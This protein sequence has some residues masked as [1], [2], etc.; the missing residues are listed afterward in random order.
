MDTSEID[1]GTIESLLNGI[2]STDSPG[3]TLSGVCKISQLYIDGLLSIKEQP[4]YSELQRGVL[5]SLMRCGMLSAKAV[6]EGRSNLLPEIKNELSKNS[7]EFKRICADRVSRSKYLEKSRPLI[8]NF[9]KDIEKL[10]LE[11][12][13]DTVIAI[14]AGGL[15]PAFAIASLRDTMKLMPIRLSPYMMLDT[16]IRVPYAC[17]GSYLDEKM[18][19]KR[20]LVVDDSVF[21]GFTIYN[22]MRFA[23]ESGAKKTCG[24]AVE[25]INAEAVRPVTKMAHRVCG[26]TIVLRYF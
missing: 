23:V 8:M 3:K 24:T 10:L 19:E 9:R 15:E 26:D 12:P 18:R 1:N 4:E 21:S 6:Y 16:D 11:E 7:E 13:F 25:I 20:V 2:E 5:D 14:S 17:S 22:A